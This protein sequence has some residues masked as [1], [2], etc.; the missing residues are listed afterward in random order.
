MSLILSWSKSVVESSDMFSKPISLTYK[1]KS[2]FQTLYGGFVSLF[3]VF[4]MLSYGIR[5][6]VQMFQRGA[7][8]KST[9]SVINGS[10]SNPIDYYTGLNNFSLAVFI[11]NDITG[12]QLYDP[13]YLNLTFIQGT[14]V[15]KGIF[16]FKG[17]IY[18][19]YL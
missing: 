2:N 19:I 16:I 12:E 11:E 10:V 5:L 8:D 13:T 18:S 15:C 3:I 7:T 1:R 14:Q 9:S 6:S 4:F 17:F